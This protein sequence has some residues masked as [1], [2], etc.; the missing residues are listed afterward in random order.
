MIDDITVRRLENGSDHALVVGKKIVY[1][2][3]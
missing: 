3:N 2:M 1:L